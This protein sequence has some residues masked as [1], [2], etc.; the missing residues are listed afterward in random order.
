MRILLLIISLLGMAISAPAMAVK[1]ATL[2]IG[3]YALVRFTRRKGST[4][5]WKKGARVKVLDEHIGMVMEDG[6]VTDYTVIMDNEDIA[7]PVGEQLEKMENKGE[8]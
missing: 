3:D 5:E 8:E 2:R 4:T 7:F 1:N 6:T